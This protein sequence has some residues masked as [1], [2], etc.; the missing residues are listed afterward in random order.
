MPLV[1]VAMVLFL[2]LSLAIDRVMLLRYCANPHGTRANSPPCCC[3]SCPSAWSALWSRHMDLRSPGLT[4]VRPRCGSDGLVPRGHACGGWTVGRRR[5]HRTRKRPRS[6][7][8]HDRHRIFR[9]HHRGDVGSEEKVEHGVDG[10]GGLSAFVAG[11]GAEGADGSALV[12][13]HRVI[14]ST[15]I[16]S[17]REMKSQRTYSMSEIKATF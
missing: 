1:Y 12:Q 6:L 13:H 14:Q 5:A 17:P 11:S 8:V 7:C 3:T 15:N 9:S 2:V 16:C 4:L 10:G